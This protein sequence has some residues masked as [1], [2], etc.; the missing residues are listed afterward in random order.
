M[1]YAEIK[2]YLLSPEMN[3]SM[4]GLE[5]IKSAL[6]YFG[7]PQKRL[8]VVHVV[9]SNG[10]GSVSHMIGGILVK[11]GYRT[12]LFC[13]PYLSELTE[14]MSVDNTPISRQ[15]FA[16]ISEYLI[17]NL[18]IAGIYLTHFEFVTLLSVLFF[19]EKDC[20]ICI[21]E[22]GLGGVSDATNIFDTAVC[23][24]LTS[25]SIEHS[26]YLGNTL[27]EI[28]AQKAGI[29]QK[30]ETIVSLDA[31]NSDAGKIVS[32]YC[33][34]KG[35]RLLE[36][37][38]EK[39][40][41]KEKS[42]KRLVFDYDEIKGIILHT[43]AL[44]Q[45]QNA[46]AAIEAVRYIDESIG[47]E[48]IL[49]GL[50]DFR[51]KGRFEMIRETPLILVDGGHNPACIREVKKSLTDGERYIIVTGVMSDKDYA[52][53]YEE[54]HELA[55]CF[56]CVDNGMPRALPSHVLCGFL[57]RY[58]VPVYNAKDTFT[59]AALVKR[60]SCGRDR[61]LFVGT[62]YMTD[63]F[64]EA[65]ELVYCEEKI[66]RRYEETVKRLTSKSFYSKNYSIDDMKLLLGEFDCPQEKLKVIHV[67]GTNG[68]GSVCSMIYTALEKLGYKTGLFTSPYIR[69]FN[70]RIFFHGSCI[71]DEMLTAIAAQV[72]D[73]QNRLGMDLNQFALVTCICFIYYRLVGADFVVL[74]TGLGGTYDPTNIVEKPL[75][76][77]ITNIGLDHTAVL[78][79]TVEKIAET[80][81]GIIKKHVPAV[82]YPVEKTAFDIIKQRAEELEAPLIAVSENDVLIENSG[83]SGTDFVFRKKRFHTSLAGD[84]QAYNAAAAIS[85]LEI[86]RDRGHVPKGEEPFR[87][88]YKC[89]SEALSEV[90]WKGR[91][92]P[93]G[94][95]PLC[96]IDGGHNT[97][98]VRN[99]TAFFEA[100]YKDWKK[101]Y[102]AGF[103]KDKD[104]E[105][106]LHVLSVSADILYLVPVNCERSLSFLELTKT[107]KQYNID[108]KVFDRL[109]KA[110]Q[111]AAATADDKTVICIIGSLYQLNDF[112]LLKEQSGGLHE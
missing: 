59:A 13:S 63:R 64:K 90:R 7:N 48:C 104:Y 107:A 110:Y 23:S 28:A 86:I 26:A 27:E 71:E 32:E 106:M 40:V 25:L 31:A 50:S 66:R 10:K 85:A 87:D 58:G 16:G 65:V 100:H 17:E 91:L 43:G 57:E 18:K 33:R 37:S 5:R 1:D 42:L 109:E 102:I 4:P 98:C 108:I 101:I 6:A 69:V 51:L 14:Y 55:S 21:Y 56:V 38:P 95:D 92:E 15:A 77:V 94:T 88:F 73:T 20:D 29:A 35:I 74:E 60:I 36:S 79:T 82:C 62:L 47:P 34:E 2:D 105:G 103:M 19:L 99:V 11:A 89:V 111:K 30:G 49:S 67:A 83:I 9:G 70:E 12:G 93:V 78:G 68:K 52:A 8:K 41:L 22:A 61:V 24:V 80:K 39:I 76:T 54:L 44:Y 81:A 75:C 45:M 46:A 84:F 53:M 3:V 72:I 96:Y 97:Q 112:Y